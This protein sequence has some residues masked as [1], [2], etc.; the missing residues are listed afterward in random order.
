MRE[1]GFSPGEFRLRNKQMNGLNQIKLINKIYME[2]IIKELAKM[3]V[4]YFEGFAPEPENKARNKMDQW[5][6]KK[7]LIHKSH[8]I[9]GHNI[10]PEG[11]LSSDPD[12]AG[13]KFMVTLE[14]NYKKDSETKI[15]FIE[16]GRFVVA[17]IE[18]NISEG[19]GK[20]IMEG[21]E[22]LNKIIIKG[23][24][25]IK[26]PIRWFEEELEPSKP[27]NLRLDLYLEIE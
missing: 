10:D 2:T 25:T 16:P 11:N 26:K 9:F 3:K 24:Y 21:W 14:N 15:D 13:Y 20:W 12:H 4:A 22:R 17:G 8:R 19:E 23:N 18:G 27:G 6:K 7:H 1:P 5:L